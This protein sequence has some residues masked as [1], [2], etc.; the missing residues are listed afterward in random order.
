MARAAGNRAITRPS[1]Q[2][3]PVRSVDATGRLV[4]FSLTFLKMD[5]QFDSL[6]SDARY[7]EL[8]PADRAYALTDRQSSSEGFHRYFAPLY[9]TV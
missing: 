3:S 5:P 2:R 7:V 9:L 1:S 4:E 8:I 6:R